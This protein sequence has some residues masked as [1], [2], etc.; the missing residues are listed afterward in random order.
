MGANTR[1]GDTDRGWA[2][3]PAASSKVSILTTQP[4]PTSSFAVFSLLCKNIRESRAYY[5][6][7]IPPRPHHC[8]KQQSALDHRNMTPCPCR[9]SR[10]FL[11][12]RPKPRRST[13]A[14]Y[15]IQAT[16]FS[17]LPHPPPPLFGSKQRAGQ[18]RSVLARPIEALDGVPSCDSQHHP[19]RAPLRAFL[20]THRTLA[21]PRLASRVSFFMAW[22][23]SSRPPI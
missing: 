10:I 12:T 1:G 13:L 3:Q 23:G 18:P 16:A 17:W 2:Q 5:Y 19:S 21:S 20:Y 6:Y 14:W 11:L 7:P 15:I 22:R 4:A 8:D 9:L